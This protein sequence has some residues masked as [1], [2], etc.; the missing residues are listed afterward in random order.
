MSE[1]RARKLIIVGTDDPQIVRILP[2]LIVD[3]ADI[4]AASKILR[5]AVAA[6]VE[7]SKQQ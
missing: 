2:P 1:C 5:E 4:A 7:K 6:L 3:D